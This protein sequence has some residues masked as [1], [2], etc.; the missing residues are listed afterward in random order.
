[1]PNFGR[2]DDV[3]ATRDHYEKAQR[4]FGTDW[5]ILAKKAKLPDPPSVPHFGMD[6][7]IVASLENLHS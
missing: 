2:D 5:D 7:D 4:D 3:N 6:G 1:V